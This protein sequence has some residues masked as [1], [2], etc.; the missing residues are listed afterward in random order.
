MKALLV[1]YSNGNHPQTRREMR[2][3]EADNIFAEGYLQRLVAFQRVSW[4]LFVFHSCLHTITRFQC[5]QWSDISL[6]KRSC[7]NVAAKS[8]QL[9]KLGALYV[10]WY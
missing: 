9:A 1:E 5:L 4:W 8:K 7:K 2:K 3:T 10:S 6:G